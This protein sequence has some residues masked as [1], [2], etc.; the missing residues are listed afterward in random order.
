MIALSVCWSVGT[1]WL[2]RLF[3]PVAASTAENASTT[4]S[5]AAT[6]APN[7]TSRIPS[8]SGREVNSA[9]PM[10]CAKRWSSWWS[11]DAWPNSSMIK[12]GLPAWRSSTAREDRARSCPPRPRPC[13]GRRT[14]RARSVGRPRRGPHEDV[15]R[16]DDV[17]H[18]GL[19]RER[20]DDA[21]DGRRERRLIDRRRE[22]LHEH[23]LARGDVEATPVEDLLGPPR[24]AVRDRPRLHLLG[25][26]GAADHHRGDARTAIQ[27]NAAS[28]QCAAL[29]RPALPAR[30][31]RMPTSSNLQQDHA[32][33][34]PA[35][36]NRQ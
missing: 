4:G 13:R 15:E 6:S 10:S 16:R 14:G 17:R 24:L 29:Q 25:A 33:T 1:T 5:P 23:A 22:G 35:H 36:C 30:F 34:L 2:T 32:R 21:G 9:R 27:P 19:T 7:A 11:A 8:V 26:D 3:S 31:V 28:F 18:V 20:L 12:L